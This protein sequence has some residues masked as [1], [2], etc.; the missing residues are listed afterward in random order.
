CRDDPRFWSGLLAF[1]SALQIRTH[2]LAVVGDRL[3]SG[4]P[5]LV[6]ETRL[7]LERARVAWLSELGRLPE[8]QTAL[9]AIKPGPDPSARVA[10]QEQRVQ[11]L[12][13]SG[14]AAAARKLFGQLPAAGADRPE[15]LHLEAE[16]AV[17]LDDADGLTSTLRRLLGNAPDNPAGY[18]YAF[19]AWQRM[20]RSSLRDTVEADYYRAFGGND[21]ALQ[22]MGALAVRL[23]LPEVLIRVQNVA[24]ASRLSP[25]AYRVHRTELALREGNAEEATRLLRDWEKNIDTLKVLQRFYP[26]FIKRLTR[27]AFTGAPDQTDYLLTHLAA[28]RAQARLPVYLG[29]ATM[30]EKSGDPAGAT[31]VVKA[32]LRR[33]PF[34]DPLIAEQA[35][36]E[37]V[38]AKT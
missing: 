14:L 31:E 32:G 12:L 34:S 10:L 4:R 17:A 16:I 33:F 15:R 2:A 25:F 36:L 9:D 38:L 3:A 30:L 24:V 1:Y 29:A 19:E 26:E 27:A 8:A 11:L 13:L 37:T 6:P 7:L 20:K 18:L 21:A 28:N 23:D 5:A 35:R 22:A